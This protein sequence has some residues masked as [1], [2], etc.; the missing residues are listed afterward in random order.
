MIKAAFTYSCG[1]CSKV[2]SVDGGMVNNKFHSISGQDWG[3]GRY[4]TA[5]PDVVALAPEGWIA[6]DPWTQCTY[7]PACW[8][9]I[10]QQVGL[11][12]I[13]E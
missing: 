11:Q 12:E 13:D 7:C 9:D 6:F 4:E 3:F 5:M 10:C 2:E 1:G 8:A